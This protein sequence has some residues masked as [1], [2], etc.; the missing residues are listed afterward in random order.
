MSN[1][2]LNNLQLRQRLPGQITVG[3]AGGSGAGK[4]TVAAAMVA[5]LSSVSVEVRGLDRFFKPA[6]ELP[7]YYSDHLAKECA[8]YNRPDSLLVEKMV[9]ACS[10]PAE[11]DV[12]I[13]DGHM[14]LCYQE[15]RQLLD[16]SCFVDAG[17]EAMLERRTE[18]NLA[19]NYGGDRDTIL[20]YNRECVVP[21]YERYILPSRQHA[22]VII[23]NGSS[24]TAERDAIIQVLCHKITS[25]VTES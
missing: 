18:R 25:S 17:I 15:M 14:V 11:A 22:Q 19:A 5:A 3:I 10:T 9:V 1:L 2:S 21:G 13:L 16:I 20:H 24:A 8:D 4:S 6:D 7:R 12:V 23:P